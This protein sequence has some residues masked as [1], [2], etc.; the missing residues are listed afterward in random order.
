M[1]KTTETKKTT[2]KIGGKT[3][4]TT[5]TTEKPVKLRK[6]TIENGVGTNSTITLTRTGYFFSL[7]ANPAMEEAYSPAGLDNF[8][9]HE[10]GEQYRRAA[11][12]LY[13]AALAMNEGRESRSDDVDFVAALEADVKKA[14]DE[15]FLLCGTRP[16]NKKTKDGDV[17]LR[18][19]YKARQA[20]FSIIGEFAGEAMRTASSDVNAADRFAESFALVIGRMFNGQ[21]FGRI[22]AAELKEAKKIATEKRNQKARNTRAK[23]QEEQEAAAEE[24]KQKQETRQTM[25]EEILAMVNA[26]HATDDEKTAI[27]AKVNEFAEMK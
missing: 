25:L 26:S 5:S 12:A 8:T 22:T 19:C 9:T 4:V 6:T 23:N 7:A 24:E 20:D 11:S 13:V 27:S 15:V 21:G 14:A 3:I 1:S 10:D 2:T 16:T 17:I 18:P